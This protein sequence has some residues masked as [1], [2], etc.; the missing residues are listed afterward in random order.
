MG[1][2]EKNRPLT[3]CPPEKDLK[4]R[5][6]YR[7]GED[8]DKASYFDQAQIIPKDIPNFSD[9][10]EDWGNEMLGSIRIVLEMLEK[11]M[12]LPKGTL[13]NMGE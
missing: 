2:D 5:Y 4:W 12:E 7:I 6:F 3:L 10:L 1:T 8:N 11:A 13:V 9:V